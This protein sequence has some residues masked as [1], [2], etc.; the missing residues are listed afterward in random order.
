M[1]HCE[2]TAVG[3]ATIPLD[4]EEVA[5]DWL[6][7]RPKCIQELFAEFPPCTV[8]EIDGIS[9]YVISYE[10]GESE[11]D[12][13][14]GISTTSPLDNYEKAVADRQYIHASHVRD[15]LKAANASGN[16]LFD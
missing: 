1:N 14:L 11:S 3:L 15:F 10:E 8:I 5:S 13:G 6:A 4:A 12:N 2:I 7:T 9:H 16:E